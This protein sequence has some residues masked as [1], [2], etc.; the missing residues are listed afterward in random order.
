MAGVLP[1]LDLLAMAA[2]ASGGLQLGFAGDSPKRLLAALEQR[3]AAAGDE[4]GGD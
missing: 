4:Q 3:D 2:A 1:A